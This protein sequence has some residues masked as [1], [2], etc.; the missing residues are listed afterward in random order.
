MVTLDPLTLEVL[1]DAHW[2]D[3]F[4]TWIYDLHEYLQFGARAR[5][6]IAY[7]A[8]VMVVVL[9]TGVGSWLLPRGSVRTKFSLRWRSA[10]RVYDLHKL[11]GAYASI[12]MLVTV[13]TGALLSIP[14]QVRL[15]L[16]T[17]SR[18]KPAE[19]PVASAPF[20]GGVRI[21][22]DQIVAKGSGYFPGSTVVW[23]RVPGKEVQTY[24]LQIRQ[25]GA[26]MSRFPRTHLFV[27]QFSGEILAV[28]NPKSD[29][30]G[31]TVLN[32]LLSYMTARHL[33]WQGGFSSV[34]SA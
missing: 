15:A 1:R 9:L 17:F 28:Y 16:N 30:W 26:P 31:D 6:W 20:A 3:T 4:F 11:G 12:F 13:T 33:G 2:S 27:D 29:G 32:W 25:A 5:P 10:M 8:L 23:V 14:D 18:L 22:V 19:P 21:P 34:V 24:D 7:V